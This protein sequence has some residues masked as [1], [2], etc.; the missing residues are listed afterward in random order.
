MLGRECAPLSGAP[1]HQRS[2]AR[3]HGGAASWFKM[4]QNLCWG[5]ALWHTTAK[6]E[7][8][9]A[10]TQPE[11]QP[12]QVRRFARRQE[13]RPRSPSAWRLSRFQ[14]GVRLRDPLVHGPTPS[15]HGHSPTKRGLS[16]TN[17][18]SYPIKI[19]HSPNTETFQSNTGTLKTRALFNQTRAFSNQTLALVNQ[20]RTLS[21]RYWPSS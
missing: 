17:H 10:A 11:T 8:L 5:N 2:A 6:L 3:R 15:K 21:T 1:H 9:R 13:A 7:A 12:W 16:P 19:G 18:G 4:A 14:P 20:T